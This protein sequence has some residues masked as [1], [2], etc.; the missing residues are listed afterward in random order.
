[1]GSHD[2]KHCRLGIE[3][4]TGIGISTDT[5][6]GISICT[7]IAH[8]AG[9]GPG[10]L[11]TSLIGLGATGIYHTGLGLAGPFWVRP[12]LE[13]RHYGPE[14]Q[15]ALTTVFPPLTTSP[16]ALGLA[17]PKRGQAQKLNENRIRR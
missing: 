16:P 8:V 17:A 1:M 6:L 15:R 3:A 10:I 12:C 2:L 11:A 4:G 5:A 7:V 9:W 14:A 13:G